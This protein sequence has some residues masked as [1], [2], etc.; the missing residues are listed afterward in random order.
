MGHI[1][2]LQTNTH[3]NASTAHDSNQHLL[4]I[5]GK[6]ALRIDDIQTTPPPAQVMSPPLSRD[7]TDVPNESEPSTLFQLHNAPNDNSV[8]N[9]QPIACKDDDTDSSDDEREVLCR[10]PHGYLEQICNYFMSDGDRSDPVLH[11]ETYETSLRFLR[12]DEDYD[13]YLTQ[14]DWCI[15]RKTM[16]YI[17]GIHNREIVPFE[18]QLKL[19]ITNQHKNLKASHLQAS[20]DFTAF[21]N[22]TSQGQLKY[23]NLALLGFEKQSVHT[24]KNSIIDELWHLPPGQKHSAA[25]V[26][27]SSTLEADQ[28]TAN[29]PHVIQSISSQLQ[30]EIASNQAAPDR[31]ISNFY[32]HLK[33]NS[34]AIKSILL[35]NK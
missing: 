20:K 8:S 25:Y 13:I 5:V 2:E 21:L 27:V 17:Q 30:A 12:E 32:K 1:M 4:S 29:K 35:I 6:H 28:S 7:M 16:A 23:Q 18:Q 22:S 9:Q 15:N 10:G 26:I 19:D 34:N 3:C 33:L 31:Q 11:S 14:K 24:I